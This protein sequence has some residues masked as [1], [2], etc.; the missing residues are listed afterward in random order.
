MQDE[1]E[2]FEAIELAF[3]DH[4]LLKLS[5]IR[6]ED[7]NVFVKRNRWTQASLTP[8]VEIAARLNLSYVI[9]DKETIVIFL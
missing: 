6:L 2:T 4:H 1:E 5:E 7:N 3:L 9:Q 8:F